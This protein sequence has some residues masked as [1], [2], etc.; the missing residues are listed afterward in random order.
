MKL[1]ARPFIQFL[2]LLKIL[3]FVMMIPSLR[4][5]GD[6][7]ETKIIVTMTNEDYSQW[8]HAIF[9]NQEDHDG[10]ADYKIKTDW[11][12]VDVYSFFGWKTCQGISYSF[13]T[14]EEFQ[15]AKENKTWNGVYENQWILN[16]QGK[17][18][19]SDP[20]QSVGVLSLSQ[21]IQPSSSSSRNSGSDHGLDDT[22]HSNEPHGKSTTVTK[23]S[24]ISHALGTFFLA[25]NV[26]VSVVAIA[27]LVVSCGAAAPAETVAAELG[28]TAEAV[29][30]RRVA[31]VLLQDV[32]QGAEG[33]TAEL[34]IAEETPHP[35]ADNSLP[36]SKVTSK[37]D[38]STSSNQTVNQSGSR[39]PS[40]RSTLSLSPSASIPRSTSDINITYAPETKITVQCSVS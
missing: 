11:S 35:S 18:M 36:N 25:V 5:E 26:L 34:E 12:I 24:T 29:I 21:K 39:L 33:E 10:E 32:A 4:G 40:P 3:F 8:Q 17:L 22:I 38:L 31:G 30:G 28:A 16:E 7:S 15:K 1:I 13:L 27:G 37:V 14:E 20:S 6:S 2:V 23:S 19:L 9:G